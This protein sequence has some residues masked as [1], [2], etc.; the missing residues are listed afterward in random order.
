[1]EQ[2]NHKTKIPI[3]AIVFLLLI[4]ALVAIGSMAWAVD[5]KTNTSDQETELFNPFTLAG[6]SSSGVNPSGIHIKRQP[7]R[8]PFKPVFRSPCKPLLR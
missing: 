6:L 1:M 5:S 8:I 3:K 7:I 2:K 4:I